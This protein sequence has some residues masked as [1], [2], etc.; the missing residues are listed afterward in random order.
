[1]LVVAPHLLVM[2]LLAFLLP[3]TL[4]GRAAAVFGTAMAAAGFFACG[5][6][7]LLLRVLR[8]V[9]PAPPGVTRTVEQLARE[10]KVRGRVKVFELEWAQVNAV[11]WESY[12]AVGFSRPLLEVMSPDEVRAVAAHELGHLLEPAWVRAV[13]I[14]QMFCYLL[15]PPVIRYGGAAGLPLAWLLLMGIALGYRRFSRR[16]EARADRLESQAIADANT[17]MRSMIKLH[18]AN[19]TPAVMPGTQTHPHLYDRLLAGGIRPG[20]PRP[21]PPGRAKPLLAVAAAAVATTVVLFLMV[22]AA[23]VA[24]RLYLSR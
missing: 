10:M 13:R 24:Q 7:V 2:L 19:P 17:Y 23:G 9:R 11:A 5:G 12:R 18:E 21:M 16:M 1:M 3:D 14:V 8:V 4:N 20:F 15:V 22:V 6:G